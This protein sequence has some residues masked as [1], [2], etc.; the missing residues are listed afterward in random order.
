MKFEEYIN[1]NEMPEVMQGTLNSFYLDKNLIIPI[2]DVLENENILRA[3]NINE[4]EVGEIPL[5]I[6]ESIFLL[7]KDRN[8]VGATKVQLNGNGLLQIKVSKKFFKNYK[9]ILI[10]LYLFISIK[11]DDYIFTDNIQTNI[12]HKIWLKLLSNKNIKD[13]KVFFDSKEIKFDIN[14][15]EKYW[16]SQ[17]YIVGVKG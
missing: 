10:D 5:N 1:L 7:Y 16:S 3:G 11:R 17:K 2:K 13:I 6:A 14:D 4:Y 8:I 15:I 12:S 9:N